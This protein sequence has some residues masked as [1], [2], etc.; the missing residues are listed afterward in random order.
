MGKRFGKP[1]AKTAAGQLVA[2]LEAGRAAEPERLRREFNDPRWWRFI[3]VAAD[4]PEEKEPLPLRS[5][6]V[7]LKSRFLTGAQIHDIIQQYAAQ[8]ATSTPATSGDTWMMAR[9]WC[10][11]SSR[12]MGEKRERCCAG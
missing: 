5:Y 6:F 1:A 2:A 3:R 7:Q 9:G 11:A 4:W 10:A 8:V 12:C